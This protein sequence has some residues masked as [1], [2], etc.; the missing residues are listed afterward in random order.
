MKYIRIYLLLLIIILL[1]SQCKRKSNSSQN[2]N[3][4]TDSINNA[5]NKYTYINDSTGKVAILAFNE[6]GSTSYYSSSD[7]NSFQRHH[8]GLEYKFII[9]KKT[10][11]RPRLGDVM[12]ID[13]IYTT[14]HDSI[15][16][17]SFDIDNNNYKMRLQALS[18]SGGCIEDAFMMMSEGDSAIFRIDAYNFF[19]N[20]LLRVN[21]PKFIKA[22]EK[23][24]FYIKMKTIIK[25]KDYL[26]KDKETYTYNL[27]QEK[28]LIDRF[29]LDYNYP[30]TTTKS[31]LTILKIKEQ[32]GIK[33][34]NGDIVEIHY[35][36][37]FIDGGI[38]DSSIERNEPFKFKIGQ[39]EVIPG[40]EEAILNMSK[41]EHYIVIIP[42]RLAYGASKYGIIPP[43]STLVFEIDL[44]NVK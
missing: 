24:I 10:R 7:T 4:A 23:L 38:F 41:G 42:F 32:N 40:L 16:F 1:F 44:I 37:G 28:S 5:T 33:P 31:G 22:N 36:A 13:M 6:D 21:V 39:N 27:Q 25:S 3:I 9:D 20:T 11:Y 30:K 26:A 17:S 18:H 8:S 15:L 34:H 43:Y 2:D 12:Y 19:K 29:L 14:I 35:T